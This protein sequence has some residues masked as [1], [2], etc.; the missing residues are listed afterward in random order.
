MSGPARRLSLKRF[1]DKKR[2]APKKPIFIGVVELTSPNETGEGEIVGSAKI[3]KLPGGALIA[4]IDARN[5]PAEILRRGFSMGPIPA[6]KTEE[7]EID[8]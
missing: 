5:M 8:A 4:H 2:M 7:K 1:K 6:A 3:E